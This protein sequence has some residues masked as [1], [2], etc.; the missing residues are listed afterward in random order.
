MQIRMEERSSEVVFFLQA[1][2]VEDSAQLLRLCGAA[3][4]CN[5]GFVNFSHN[6]VAGWLSMPLRKDM[7]KATESGRMFSKSRRKKN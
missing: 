6:M 3:V 4:E 5:S 7:K 2:S 1:D